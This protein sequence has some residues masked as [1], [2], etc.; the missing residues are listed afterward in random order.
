MKKY[1]YYIGHK[2]HITENSFCKNLNENLNPWNNP[3][4]KAE[5]ILLT[6]SGG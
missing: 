3:K 4:E 2:F 5:S 6:L 1:Y